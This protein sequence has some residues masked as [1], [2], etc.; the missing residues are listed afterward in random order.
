MATYFKSNR[1][2]LFLPIVAFLVIACNNKT[3][4]KATEKKDTTDT[5]STSQTTEPKA[6]F[7]GV[8]LDILYTDS[9]S[10]NH[11]KPGNRIFF[12]LTYINP[13]IITLSG[14]PATGLGGGSFP[15][16]PIVL[17]KSSSILMNA[18]PVYVGNVKL[19][20]NQVQ[21]VKDDI[22]ATNAA[23]VLFTPSLSSTYPNHIQ[24]TINYTPDDP[25]K[26]KNPA[27]IPTAGTVIANPSPP[28]QL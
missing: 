16:P 10:F 14:F 20:P 21:Q 17:Q 4:E 9:S 1:F 22:K 23:F 27:L 25:A 18:N 11:L 3:D 15:D 19:D 8:T 5:T 12:V 24:Y 6:A 7:T 28:K 2:L 26:T 13:D